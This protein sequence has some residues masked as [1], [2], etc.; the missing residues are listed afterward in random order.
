MDIL[1]TVKKRLRPSRYVA[2][3]AGHPV[4]RAPTLAEAVNAARSHIATCYTQQGIAVNVKIITPS[5]RI[6]YTVSPLGIIRYKH[7]KA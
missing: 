7:P 3:I 2:F 4:S 1:V 6:N 5:R